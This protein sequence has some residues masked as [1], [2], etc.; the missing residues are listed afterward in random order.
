[1]LTSKQRARLRSQ[2]NQ[3]ET[4]LQIGK[5]GVTENVITQ[6]A[7]ALAAREM[8]KLRVLE[9]CMLTAKEAA[10][11]LS[12]KT[13]SEVVHVIGS[14]IVLYKQFKKDPIYSLI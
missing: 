4:I 5:D 3:M 1:M 12:G 2:A 10:F 11:E 13:N 6:V 14:R 9:N 7:D 8:I